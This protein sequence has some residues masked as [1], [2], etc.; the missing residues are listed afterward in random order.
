M[1]IETVKVARPD[2]KRL[3]YAIINKSDMT[4]DDKPYKEPKQAAKI[5]GAKSSQKDEKEAE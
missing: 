1:S 3:G 5:G 4:D 2:H